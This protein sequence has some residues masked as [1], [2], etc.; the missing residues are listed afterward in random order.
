MMEI[1]DTLHQFQ[2]FL[3]IF[4]LGLAKLRSM[5]EYVV[6]MCVRVVDV[7]DILSETKLAYVHT[8]SHTIFRVQLWKMK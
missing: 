5:C 6:S 1:S 7:G 2:S 3:S 8:H 4:M